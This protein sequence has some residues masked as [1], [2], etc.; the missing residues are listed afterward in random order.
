[1]VSLKGGKFRCLSRDVGQ[2]RTLLYPPQTTLQLSICLSSGG[3]LFTPKKVYPYRRLGVNLGFQ[4][5]YGLPYRLKDFYSFPTWARAMAGV[6][7]GRVLPTEVISARAARKRRSKRHL[8]AGDVYQAL[9]EGLKIAGYDE[10]C[11]VKSVCELAHSPFHSIE[12]NLYAEIIYFILSPSEHK[13]FE[14]NERTMRVKYETAEQLGKSGTDCHLLYPKCRN[15]FL[16]DISIYVKD[17]ESNKV[18]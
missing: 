4:V 5:N 17:I 8:S 6:I 13:S 12:E 9:D 15:S 7:K 3:P 11:L 18:R 10:D 16:N 1:M 14:H 2:E